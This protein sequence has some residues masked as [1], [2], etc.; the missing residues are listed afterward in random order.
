MQRRVF[1]VALS[2]ALLVAASSAWSQVNLGLEPA[3]PEQ[4]GV[5]KEKLGRVHDVL[6]E[7]IDAGRLPGTVVM[8]ARKGKVI[9]ADAAGFQDKERRQTDGARRHL[10]HLFDDQTAGFRRRHDAG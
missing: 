2:G 8:V 5:S 3:L 10:S 9:Y 6:Q 1:V 4:V 7:H